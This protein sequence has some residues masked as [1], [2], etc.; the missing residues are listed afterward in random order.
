[1]MKSTKK[2]ITGLAMLGAL[3]LAGAACEASGDT[4]TSPGQEE[5]PVEGGFE[6]PATGDTGTGDAGLEGEGTT[7][8]GF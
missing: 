8:G 6:D 5:A 3:S 7:D 1:M 4:G 2:K